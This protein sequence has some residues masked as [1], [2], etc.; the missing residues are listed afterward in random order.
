MN[1]T[2][3]YL[4]AYSTTQRCPKEEE[5]IMMENF[6][7]LPPVSTTPVVH[8]ELR[9]SPQIFKKIRNSPIGIIRGL[10][11][12]DLWSKKS[13]DTVPLKFLEIEKGRKRLLSIFKGIILSQYYKIFRVRRFL[14]FFCSII[15]EK[16]RTFYLSLWKNF[17]WSN[18]NSTKILLFKISSGNLGVD[19]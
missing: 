3:F 4:Y 14:G 18:C 8:L 12:T 15:I 10:G 6:F 2:F 1:L 11:E 13:R 19:N 5:K 9:I 16:S 7:H 17:T